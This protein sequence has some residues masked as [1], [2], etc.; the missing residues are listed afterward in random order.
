MR[1]RRASIEWMRHPR[2]YAHPRSDRD[3]MERE[4]AS[5]TPNGVSSYAKAQERTPVETDLTAQIQAVTSLLRQAEMEV[6]DLLH[7]ARAQ[8]ISIGLMDN[9]IDED[10]AQLKG[11]LHYMQL[12]VEHHPLSP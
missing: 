5:Q 9:H 6:T 2:P 11:R 3:T 10:I 8:G 1:H 4:V 7:A 12:I